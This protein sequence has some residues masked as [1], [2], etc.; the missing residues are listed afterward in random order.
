VAVEVGVANLQTEYQKFKCPYEERGESEK[1][2]PK[3]RTAK[4]T[5]FAASMKLYLRSAYVHSHASVKLR[6]PPSFFS[7]LPRVARL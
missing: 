1:L 2:S 7:H 5:P 3:I 4:E 6:I